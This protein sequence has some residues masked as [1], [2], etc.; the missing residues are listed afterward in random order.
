MTQAYPLQWP[1][2]YPRTGY[3]KPSR[4]GRS[5]ADSRDDLLEQIRRLGGTQVV[6]SSNAK[7]RN[8]GLPY[9]KQP[10]VNDPG[11]A[12]YFLYEGEQVVFACDKWLDIGDNIRALGLAIEAIRGLER[13]GVSQMLKRT[14]TG[15]KALAEPATHKEEWWSV[16][17]VPESASPDEIRKAYI[18]LAQ[19]HHPD[20][21]GK[22]DQFQKI[23]NAYEVAK[24]FNGM[25]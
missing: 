18:K 8:D 3:R 25:N 2:S 16:L 11:V 22:A 20:K 9:S 19:R 10:A 24:F 4:F 7:L 6:I 21:G 12:V 23:Q 14:F 17:E 15:F 13:W 5:L 1:A